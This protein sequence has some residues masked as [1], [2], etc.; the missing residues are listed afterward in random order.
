MQNDKVIKETIFRLFKILRDNAITQEREFVILY[1][2]SCFQNNVELDIATQTGEYGVGPDELADGSTDIKISEP[3]F[4]LSHT[5]LGV[6]F[7][8]AIKEIF[9]KMIQ[10]MDPDAARDLVTATK[11]AYKAI[12]KSNYSKLFEAALLLITKSQVKKSGEFMLPTEIAECLIKIADL[13]AY[14]SVFNPFSGMATFGLHLR[15]SSKYEAQEI[16]ELIHAV[17]L[18]R[19]DAH[20]KLTKSKVDHVDSFLSW[21]TSKEYDL[22]IANTPF[23]LNI[24]RIQRMNLALQGIDAKSYKTAQHFI[25][26]EGLKVLKESGKLILLIP[27]KFLTSSSEK[28]VRKK[29]IENDL[30]EAVITFP[31]RL[32]TNT[33]I[34]FA[35]L[36]LNKS[37]SMRDL[38]LF[39][40]ADNFTIE[41][42]NELLFNG[43]GF[44]KFYRRAFSR[45]KDRV[46]STTGIF[47][48]FDGIVPLFIDKEEIKKENYKLNVALFKL[49][50]IYGVELS[51]VLTLAHGI[52]KRKI[53]NDLIKRNPLN[54]RWNLGRKL[55]HFLKEDFPQEVKLNEENALISN[56]T[57]KET[58]NILDTLKYVS[59]KDLKNDPL[60]YTLSIE[61]LDNK[62]I[63]EN[64]RLISGDVLLI[65]QIG[66][67]IKPTYI[68]NSS[69]LIFIGKNIAAFQL[70]KPSVD[71]DWLIHNFHLGPLSEQ[72]EA[73]RT[74][75]GIPYLSK[76]DFLRVKI[77]LPDLQEQ[78][79]EIEQIRKISKKID[80]LE[81]DIIQQNAYIRHTLAGPVADLTDAISNIDGVLRN[82]VTQSFPDVLRTKMTEDH[83]F[84]LEHYL[85]TA[86][87]NS[88]IIHRTIKDKLNVVQKVENA[89]L[90]PL[91]L[92]KFAEDYVNQKIHSN[93]DYDLVFDF[94]KELVSTYES[95]GFSF[96]MNGNKD[97]LRHMFDNFIDNAKKHAFSKNGRG[98]FE[99]YL[100]ANMD[101]GNPKHRMIVLI[102]A[103]TGNPMNPELTLEDIIAQGFSSGKNS[104]NG[105]GAWYIDLVIR[106]HKGDWYYYQEGLPEKPSMSEIVTSFEVNF[107]FL[108]E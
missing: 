12:P 85:E 40:E 41:K 96:K 105:F 90:E 33:N 83:L 62:T 82:V 103:N 47:R 27:R 49:S 102:M 84:D 39:L 4:H 108:S 42:D 87:K 92:Q 74:G 56:V 9:D 79:H 54:Y 95:K 88:D 98:R 52:T 43:E 14:A 38:V 3:H 60:D 2:L 24:N 80:S 104:G 64:S 34:P 29:L 57:D 66:N 93:L 68:P 28:G 75:S 100:T 25:C 1:L 78:K 7:L 23:D 99:I 19:L 97:L 26:E 20:N 32:L 5:P 6:S 72:F 10:N 59:V 67:S 48:S 86:R 63:P 13:P 36:V 30:V 31:G 77:N 91:D 94:D 17:S 46:T 11:E 37:K 21:P 45:Y 44:S 35:V 8:R 65:S 69:E 53:I 81:S 18:L 58:Y 76:E 71:L 70:K 107:P 51:E 61:L 89:V 73:L 106:K 15:S 101:D 50:G 16:N 55:K 22:L